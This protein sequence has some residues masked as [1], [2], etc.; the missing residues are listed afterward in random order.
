MLLFQR[1]GAVVGV[2]GRDDSDVC[3]RPI[4][5]AAG[6][7]PYRWEGI[8]IQDE[9]EGPFL[10]SIMLNNFELLLKL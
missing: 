3:L 7:Y 8:Q 2:G 6:L 4:V 9:E 1:V 10:I 5:G